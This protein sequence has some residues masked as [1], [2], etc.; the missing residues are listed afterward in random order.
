M[1]AAHS[2]ISRQNA[3]TD[4]PPL[5]EEA[6][7]TSN[8]SCVTVGVIDGLVHRRV[9]GDCATETTE[10]PS[11]TPSDQSRV[12]ETFFKPASV[13]P[14]LVAGSWPLD[15][16]LHDPESYCMNNPHGAPS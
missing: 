4:C 13:M 7:D 8:A 1:A 10:T 9:C 6:L 3:S 15:E 12:R 16:Q 5:R 11:A 2:V 14:A